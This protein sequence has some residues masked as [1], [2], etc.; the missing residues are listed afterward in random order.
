VKILLAVDGSETA[1][2]ATRKLVEM[3]AWF[4][5]PPHVELVTVHLPLPHVG[6]FAGA[7]VNHDMVSRYYAEEGAKVL[8]A[9]QKLLDDAKVQY[10]PHVL[11][12]EVA[13]AIIDHAQKAGC[14]LICLGTRGRSAI[15]N[16][17][18]GSVATKV[19]HL[20]KVPVLLVH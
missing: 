20:A 16:L 12:G 14:E 11:V 5:D 1:T 13:H 4:K 7:V 9:P 18:L 17:V 6:G 10:V 3:G 19:L 2:R 8:A 15:S